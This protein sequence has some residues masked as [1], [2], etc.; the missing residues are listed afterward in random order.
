MIYNRK[1]IVASNISLTSDARQI[2]QDEVKL[3]IK[4]SYHKS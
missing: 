3:F 4:I 2:Q 1:I